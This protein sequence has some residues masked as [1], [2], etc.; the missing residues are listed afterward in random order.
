MAIVY[1]SACQFTHGDLS[2]HLLIPFIS[3][4]IEPN[5]KLSAVYMDGHINL[6]ATKGIAQEMP[7]SLTYESSHP[8]DLF[9]FHGKHANMSYSNATGSTP[10]R[11][12]LQQKHLQNP[13]WQYIS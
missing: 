1:S 13:L 8:S 5:A 3:S 9:L 7:M 10:A 6:I 11:D 12:P 2:L 4:S